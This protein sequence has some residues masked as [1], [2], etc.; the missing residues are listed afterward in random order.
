M[1]PSN[2]RYIAWLALAALAIASLACT[3]SIP[4]RRPANTPIPVTTEAVEELEKGVKESLDES[5]KTGLLEL[6]LTESQITSY[7]AF[8]LNEQ[9]EPLLVDPQIYLRD[10]QVE[11]YATLKSGSLQAPATIIAKVSV[12]AE[13]MPVVA[14]ESVNLGP[15]PVPQDLLDQVNTTLNQMVGD[16]FSGMNGRFVLESITIGEGVMTISGRMP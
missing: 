12:G 6:K 13:G 4:G 2:I 11:I 14:V 9:P 8:K 10:N 1:R 16:Q 15:L 3:L 5:A 7:V